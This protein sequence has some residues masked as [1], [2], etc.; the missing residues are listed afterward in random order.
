MAQEIKTIRCTHMDVRLHF[1][2]KLTIQ[3]NTM[4]AMKN[5][6]RRYTDVIFP[7]FPS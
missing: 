5:K 3:K 7:L 6:H 2:M 1:K 4:K